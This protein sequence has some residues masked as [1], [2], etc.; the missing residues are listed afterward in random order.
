MSGTGSVIEPR[1]QR[2]CTWLLDFNQCHKIATN[3]RGVDQVV[4]PY[5]TNNPYYPRPPPRP[6]EPQGGALPGEDIYSSCFNY[7]RNLKNRSLFETGTSP[8]AEPL[9]DSVGHR[10]LPPGIYW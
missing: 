3:K 2:L 7:M 5:F 6:R 8:S 10:H 1:G 9:K 4:D